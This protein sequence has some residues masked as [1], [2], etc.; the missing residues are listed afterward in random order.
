M[1][2]EERKD[3]ISEEVELVAKVI[4]DFVGDFTGRRLFGIDRAARHVIIALDR[5][6]ALA[7]APNETV[8]PGEGERG[9][10]AQLRAAIA[11]RDTTIT[12][13]EAEGA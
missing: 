4:S 12:E 2:P 5:R 1:T 6:R 10:L 11:D 3:V 13:P 9:A 8:D 7:T